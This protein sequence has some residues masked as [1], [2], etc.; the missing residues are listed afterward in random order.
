[1]K[2]KARAQVQAGEAYRPQGTGA[3]GAYTPRSLDR[4]KPSTGVRADISKPG[5]RRGL[6]STL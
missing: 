2:E 1:M 4:F 5:L 6:G 3:G